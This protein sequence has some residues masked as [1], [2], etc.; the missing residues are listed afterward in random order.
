VVAVGRVSKECN[1]CSTAPRIERKCFI[2]PLCDV[3]IVVDIDE[4][5]NTGVNMSIGVSVGVDVGA[6]RCRQKGV[7]RRENV[8]EERKVRVKACKQRRQERGK[9]N[10]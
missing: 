10:I 9:K 2:N 4:D 8:G 3:V 1:T 6:S 5:A 7:E